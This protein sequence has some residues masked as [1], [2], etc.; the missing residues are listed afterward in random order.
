M[1]PKH[2][3]AIA[4][5]T[6]VLGGVS[7]AIVVANPSAKKKPSV[8]I[9]ATPVKHSPDNRHT[10]EV[11]LN[12]HPD[13]RVYANPASNDRDAD[14]F[15]PARI[16]ISSLSGRIL[17]EDFSGLSSRVALYTATDDY[18]EGYLTNPTVPDELRNVRCGSVVLRRH[19]VVGAGCVILPGVELGFGSSVGALSCVRKSV[20]ELKVCVGGSTS[21]RVI[22]ERSRE[23]LSALESR[24][25]TAKCAAPRTAE[26]GPVNSERGMQLENSGQPG[27]SGNVNFSV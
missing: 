8:A 14:F 11:L 16:T 27:D 26:H 6:I 23:R 21:L 20:S 12:I 15:L 22:G 1:H 13:V 2:G 24:L 3:S 19:V 4:C 10:L 7:A 18:R 9:S 25:R 5:L 17:M